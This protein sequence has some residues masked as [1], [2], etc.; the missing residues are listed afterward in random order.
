M[1]LSALAFNCAESMDINPIGRLRDQHEV[2]TTDDSS[3]DVPSSLSPCAPEGYTLHPPI[4]S[5]ISVQEEETISGNPYPARPSTIQFVQIP[6]THVNHTY[7]D[8]A[9]MPSDPTSTIPST[10]EQMT[11]HEKLY[12]LLTLDTFHIHRAIGW[13]SH[14]R[15]FQILSV[16]H[17]EHSGILRCYFG[18]NTIQRFRKQLNV[19]G[20][21]LLTR[22]RS[23]ETYYSE[24]RTFVLSYGRVVFLIF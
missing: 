19:H 12:H 2:N 6:R 17:L 21:K 24:V 14:G 3:S 8:F 23:H 18:F 16:E 5:Y 10:I 4:G 15:A 13:C 7:R 1:A 22:A 11:F 9:E 20:Y